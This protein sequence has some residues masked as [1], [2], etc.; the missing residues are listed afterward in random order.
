MII[1]D[2]RDERNWVLVDEGF[3]DRWGIRFV[4]SGGREFVVVGNRVVCEIK[5]DPS[6]FILHPPADGMGIEDM[7]REA[8]RRLNAEREKVLEKVCLDLGW[9]EERMRRN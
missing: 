8:V 9:I 5:F 1:V 3:R 7:A 4:E 2:E 6:V